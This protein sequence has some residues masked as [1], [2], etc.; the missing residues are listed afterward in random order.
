MEP[1]NLK[2][3]AE[4]IDCENI[5]ES[6]KNILVRNISTDTRTLKKG[7]LYFAIKGKN[8]DGH[9]FIQIAE[10][11]GACGI[12]CSC[13]NIKT[14]LP[15][16][17]VKDTVKALQDLATF[18]RKG[19][20][21]KIIA[22]TGS[23]GKTTTKN[24]IY[25]VLMS[26]YKVF[27]AE[28]NFNNEIGVPKSI[29]K[30]DNSYDIAVIELGMNHA[31]EIKLLSDIVR[32]DIAIITSIGKAHIG[33]LGSIENIL[34][35]KLEILDGL[36]QNAPVIINADDKL[37]KDLEFS[38]YKKVSIGISNFNV[39]DIYASDIKF[40]DS[41]LNF[42]VNYDNKTFSLK[43]PM[44]GKYNIYNALFAIYIGLNFKVDI[45]DILNAIENYNPLCSMRNEISSVNGITIIKDYY[46]SSPD[47]ALA[48]IDTLSQYKK[49]GK[50]IAILGQIMELGD[51]SSEE[52]LKLAS[53]CCL[54]QIDHVF[55]IGKDYKSFKVGMPKYCDSFDFNERNLLFESLKKFIKDNKISSEDTILIKGSRE[56]KMEE[57]YE[58]LKRCL[59]GEDFASYSPSCTKLYIDLNAVKYNFLQIKNK[60]GKDV[61]VMPMVKANAYGIGSDIIS[62]LFKNCKYLAVADVKEASQIRKML[63]LVNLVIIYQSCLEDIYQIVSKNFIAAVSDINFAKALNEE[64]KRQNKIVKIHVEI[65]TGHARLGINLSEVSNFAKE[66]LNLKNIVVEG[67][68]MHYAAADSLEE[69]DLKFTELQTQRF[70]NGVKEFENIY[71]QVKFRHACAGPA[72]FN[73]KTEKFNMV[74]PGYVLYG[75]YP[76]EFIKE[77]VDLKPCL[78]LTSTILKIREVPENT[79][80]SYN[81]RFVTKRKSKIA[82]I[83][84]G[85]SDGI[86]RSLFNGGCFVVNGQKAP[87]AGTI[88]MDLTMIDITDIKGDIKVGDEVAIFDNIN[89]TVD[90]MANICGTIGYEIIS[91]IAEKTYRVETF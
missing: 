41:R 35:A 90:D 2:V 7:D 57:I 47:S 62:N 36:K 77:K 87:I 66:L 1:I 82:T 18:Y 70:K 8:F 29:L 48:S 14:N 53:F 5:S 54:K 75:Y 25:E 10:E 73:D 38:K 30:I 67:L 16:L 65:D 21:S 27:S 56:M 13:K 78:K 79:P 46:N 23:N 52:H 59:E 61:E 4:N 76:C 81:R 50:K 3:I 80:I 71:G 58:Y 43:L 12:V 74:R 26:K 60:V 49:S 86:F 24:M 37:L 20:K 6:F 22:I 28:R 68:F 17:K 34:K 83:A 63:S 32:P 84:I 11:K 39:S 64:A 91:R 40:E 89:V 33:N 31:G 51:L 88:C 45:D 69:S 15:F 72:I 19:L 85:Y 42:K 44:I 55:F 9:T